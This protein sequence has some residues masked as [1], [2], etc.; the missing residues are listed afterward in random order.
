MTLLQ[1]NS[2]LIVGHETIDYKH[3]SL[4]HLLNILHKAIVA[5]VD[6][7]RLLRIFKKLC[8]HCVIHFAEEESHTISVDFNLWQANRHEHQKFTKSLTSIM[9]QIGSGEMQVGFAIHK[10]VSDWCV[11]H[12]S[13]SDRRIADFLHKQSTPETTK[14]RIRCEANHFLWPF[15]G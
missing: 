3:K 2:S 1:W 4:V 14:F 13:M 9:N 12:I 10:F 11:E 8:R 15:P 7:G 5:G 6:Q